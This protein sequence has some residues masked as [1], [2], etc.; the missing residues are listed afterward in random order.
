MKASMAFAICLFIY[1]L[2][3]HIWNVCCADCL[4]YVANFREAGLKSE[5]AECL[6]LAD[7]KKRIFRHERLCCLVMQW[8]KEKIN[9]PSEF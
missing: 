9:E 6:D 1:N 5:L 8:N 3:V 7:P 4:Q 2:S